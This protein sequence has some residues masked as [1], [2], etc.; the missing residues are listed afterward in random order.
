MAALRFAIDRGDRAR[1]GRLVASY[2]WFWSIRSQHVEAFTWAQ[3]VLRLPGEMDPASEI[4]L[5]AL[6][7]TGILAQSW[8]DPDD[9]EADW[10]APVARILELWDA[11]RPADPMVDVV[12]AALDFFDLTGDREPRIPDDIWTR[13]TSRLIRVV[14]LENIGRVGESVELLDPTIEDFRSIGD[15]WG[16][17]M[18]LSQRGM[19]QSLDGDFEAALASWEEAVPLLHVLGAAEDIEFSQMKIIGLRMAIGDAQ[20]LDGVRDELAA[21]LQ[22]AHRHGDRRAE[23][24]T[25]TSLAQLEHLVGRDAV[26]LEHLEHVVANLDEAVQFGGGQL[27]AAM[28]TQLAVARACVGELDAALGE[29]TRAGRLA[30]TTQDMPIVADV[31]SAGAVIAHRLGDDE[32]AARLLGAADAIRGRSDLMNRDVRELGLTLLSSLGADAVEA[33]RLDGATLDADSAIALACQAWV[34]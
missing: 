22:N 32:R 7:I 4:G 18:G 15:R 3:T 13:A 20:E 11:H 6:A 8:R 16:V 30:I 24:V 9:G 12:L 19:I 28:R 23:V 34:R 14:L 27:E 21:S 26:A 31:V 2:A 1:A 17:A 10:A 29:L 33:H 25:R 5:Q